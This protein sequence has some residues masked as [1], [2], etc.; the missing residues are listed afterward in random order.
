MINEHRSLDKPDAGIEAQK[1]II[2]FK[3]LCG[4]KLAEA[5]SSTK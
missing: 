4:I 2:Q 3:E 1:N 5:S